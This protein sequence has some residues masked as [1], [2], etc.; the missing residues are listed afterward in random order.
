MRRQFKSISVVFQP[1]SQGEH[2]YSR[3]CRACV[4]YHDFLDRGLLLTEKL[5]NQGF[6]LVKL[7]SS[8]RK[9][10]GSHNH[11]DNRYGM[12]VSQ[13]TTDIFHFL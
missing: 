11:L 5:L 1:Y 7:M 3:Y 8:L 4:S 2:I 13:M 9:V 6:L 10:Y 12:S